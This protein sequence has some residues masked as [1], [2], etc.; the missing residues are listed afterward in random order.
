MLK[1]GGQSLAAYAGIIVDVRS[2]AVDK[3]FHYSIPETLGQAAVGHRVL[4]PFGSRRVEGYILELT[5]TPAVEHK[6]IR[7]IISLLDDMPML[8]EAQIAAAKWMAARYV[9]CLCQALQLFLPPGT[10]YGRERVARRTRLRY[11][12]ASPKDWE[13]VLDNLPSQAVRQRAVIAELKDGPQWATALTKASGASYQTLQRLEEKGLIVRFTDAVRRSPH[14]YA[15]PSLPVVLSRDQ[16]EA[17]SLIQ[18]ERNGNRLPVL[19]HGV[20]GSG[21]TEVYLQC[22]SQVAAEGRQAVVLVPEI[23]LTLQTVSRFQNRFGDRIAVLHSGLS[24]GERFDEWWRI[25]RGEVAVVIGARSAV[26]APVT[27]LGLIILDEE[28]ETTYKNEEG[29]IKYHA[30]D[31]AAFRCGQEKAQLVLG[32]ATPSLESYHRAAEGAYRLMPMPD[33]V[34]KRSLPEISVVD[35]RKEFEH[36][37]RSM[38]SGELTEALNGVLEREEQAVV[39]LNRRG[40]SS[41][42]LCREC[43]LVIECRNCQVSLTF[44]QKDD[45]LR[46]HYCG[47]SESVPLHCPHCGSPYLRRFGVGTEQV[48]NYIRE[49]FPKARP[50]RLDADTTVRRGS[51]GYLLDSFRRGAADVLIGTQMIAKGLDFPRVTLVGVLSADLSLNFPDFRS[52]ERTFQLLTQVSGRAGRGDRLGRVVIQSYEPNHFAIEAARS[53][54]YRS[55]YQKELAYRHELQYP[56]FVQF[57]RILLSGPPGLVEGAASRV[58]N[59]IAEVLPEIT[60]YGPMPAPLSRLKGRERWHILLKA[61]QNVDAVLQTIP[62]PGRGVV[63]SV[64]TDPLFFL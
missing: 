51:H 3:V 8:G 55:F 23:A 16:Q 40:H 21:K 45:H 54:D 46:C 56:P 38:F 33:R 43:G 12:L 52:S 64:D 26:F 1:G 53:Q 48:E 20:T 63:L 17:I 29:G 14:V 35:M 62:E 58:G 36:G 18:D 28:H 44:H 5:E 4:V 59:H 10:R 19:L 27:D 15:E 7:P 47:H 9:G 42:V 2:S 34:A 22:I 37:N 49:N 6:R 57:V 41:F 50:V 61:V 30:R 25:R 24:L 31:V 11:Q 32:S 13:T 39:F 60:R